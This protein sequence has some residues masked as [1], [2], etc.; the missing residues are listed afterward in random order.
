[1]EENGALKI[2]VQRNALKNFTVILGKH[3]QQ[4]SAVV[5]RIFAQN[6][7]NSDET[8][9]WC[10]TAYVL[11]MKFYFIGPRELMTLMTP[12]SNTTSLAFSLMGQVV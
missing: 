3:W 2:A 5:C 1:M 4:E 8:I 7:P 12:S 11:A 10:V 9:E 6:L